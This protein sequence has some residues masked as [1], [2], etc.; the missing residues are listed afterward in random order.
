ML[1]SIPKDLNRPW[2]DPM[3]ETD[4]RHLAQELRGVGLSAYDMPDWKKDAFGN[5]AIPCPYRG[6]VSNS[7]L[8][9]VRR[10]SC[11]GT[12]EREWM[13]WSSRVESNMNDLVSKVPKIV[14]ATAD[15][16]GEYEKEEGYE[17]DA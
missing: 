1:D 12:L 7:Q 2:E 8:C 11:I 5:S 13:R 6:S 17:E 15:E 9:S 16:E 14:D 3:P 4:E 10:L